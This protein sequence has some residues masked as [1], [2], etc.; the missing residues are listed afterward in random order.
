MTRMTLVLMLFFVAGCTSLQNA[1]D[2]DPRT[3]FSALKTFAWLDDTGRPADD[4]RLDNPLVQETVRAAVEQSLLAKGY[5]KVEGSQADFVVAWFGAIEKK[6]KKENIDQFYAPYGYAALYR[7]PKYN[8][9]PAKTMQEY[10][11]GTLIID[12][13]DPQGRKL[14]WQGTG[15]RRVV[16]GQPQQTALKNLTRAVTKI[17]E[18][19]PSR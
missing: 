19:F 8:P 17:L 4:V 7:D 13:L 1:S 18:P 12:I 2:L 16:E 9:G 5:E 14:L 10:E 6:L 11:E 3:D 15:N